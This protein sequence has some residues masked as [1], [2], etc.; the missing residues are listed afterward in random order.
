MIPKSTKLHAIARFNSDGE[1]LCFCPF[2]DFE[3]GKC[4]CRSSLG[5]ELCPE[6]LL[7]VTVL[8]NKTH[9]QD[10]IV[11]DLEKTTKQIQKT[12]TRIKQGVTQLENSIRN[13]RFKI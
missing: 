12:T 5:A 8:P 9:T 3:E 7:E 1:I 13:S 11:S 4:K 6:V 10:K 2:K